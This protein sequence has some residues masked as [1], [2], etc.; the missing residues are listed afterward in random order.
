MGFIVIGVIG[1]NPSGNNGHDKPRSVDLKATAYL[2][3]AALTVRNSD[4]FDWTD[5]E[6]TLDVEGFSAGYSLRTARIPAG[7]SARFP[8][9]EFV[10]LDRD[11]FDPMRRKPRMVLVSCITP[12]GKGLYGATFH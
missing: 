12:R 6:L 1:S 8:L 4:T 2:G 5:C 3:A 9:L 10:N 7:K 11:R